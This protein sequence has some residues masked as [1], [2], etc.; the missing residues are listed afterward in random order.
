MNENSSNR[1]SSHLLYQIVNFMSLNT[2]YTQNN[3]EFCS[4]IC[5][6]IREIYIRVHREDIETFYGKFYPDHFKNLEIR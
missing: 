3:I 2:T 4:N 5:T 6:N 1:F